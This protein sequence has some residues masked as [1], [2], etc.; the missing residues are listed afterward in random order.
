MIINLKIRH[1]TT[2]IIKLK[3]NILDNHIKYKRHQKDNT[4]TK[5]K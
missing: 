3:L 4:N 2:D 1:I 5:K